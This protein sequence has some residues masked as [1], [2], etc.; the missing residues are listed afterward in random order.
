MV[1][2]LQKGVTQDID[3]VTQQ[4]QIVERPRERRSENTNLE[5]RFL[6]TSEQVE[7]SIDEH[8]DSKKEVIQI[9]Q[10]KGKKK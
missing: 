7:E 5:G 9:G 1:E 10:Q 3:V 2:E 8:E 6:S 4:S